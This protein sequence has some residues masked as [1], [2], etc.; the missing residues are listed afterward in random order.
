MSCAPAVLQFKRR[1]IFE[2]DDVQAFG[3]HAVCHVQA[4]RASHW[5]FLMFH[6]RSVCASALFA[7][8]SPATTHQTS[9]TH[10][11]R[12]ASA[13]RT[14]NGLLPSSATRPKHQ[15]C[16]ITFVPRGEHDVPWSSA[17]ASAQSTSPFCVNAS[18]YPAALTTRHCREL[19]QSSLQPKHIARQR[20]KRE[21]TV[22][23]LATCLTSFS[24]PLT[25]CPAHCAQRC[26]PRCQCPPGGTWSSA[27]SSATSSGHQRLHHVHSV[28]H[29]QQRR[30]P[31]QLEP[32]STWQLISL[33]EMSR[34]VAECD[35]DW[36]T[37]LPDIGLLTITLA[38]SLCVGQLRAPSTLKLA[39]R[40]RSISISVAGAHYAV[41]SCNDSAGAPRGCIAVLPTRV[42]PERHNSRTTSHAKG[43]HAPTHTSEVGWLLATTSAPRPRN[44][45]R[46]SPPHKTALCVSSRTQS[47]VGESATCML[48]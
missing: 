5:N 3:V 16:A 30:T 20:K 24:R 32:M 29:C 34:D 2:L 35:F 45:P 40:R 28:P 14:R 39:S 41:R 48:S 10:Q 19:R 9:K 43:F 12:T 4:A 47:I 13:A 31:E 23:V 42:G 1:Q 17:S 25:H 36:T 37:I 8:L 33:R 15:Q 46:T 44:H 27:P 22:T 38:S 21:V 7:F 18:C 6:R 11:K 26:E